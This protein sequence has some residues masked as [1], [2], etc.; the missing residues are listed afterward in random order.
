MKFEIKKSDLL[1]LLHDTQINPRL[2]DLR[3]KNRAVEEQSYTIIAAP[4][5]SGS[6]WIT[7]V[8]AKS[9]QL[10]VVRYCYAW[11]SNEHDIY[12][13]ALLANAQR[14]TISQLH[15]RATPHNVQ[16]IADF[17]INTVIITRNVYDTVVSFA[18]DLMKKKDANIKT[19]G[20]DGYAFVWLNNCKEDWGV[21]QYIDYSIKYYLPW[22]INFLSSWSAYKN[23]ISGICV[24]Y[25]KLRECPEDVFGD[26][27]Q[28]IDASKILHPSFNENHI[29]SSRISGTNSETGSSLDILSNGQKLQI[30]SFFEG[31]DDAWVKSHLTTNS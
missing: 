27:I 2:T 3:W 6:T 29:N 17:N 9:L 20:L 8:L 31:M 16:L 28:K 5:K 7:N 11:S 25:E 15:M 21:E 24:R 10:E 18:R 23:L 19:I 14:R 26:V 13:P 4:P 12:V 22:Y 1:K 30:N